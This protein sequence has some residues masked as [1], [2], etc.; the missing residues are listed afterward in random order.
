MFNLYSLTR[1]S[2]GST[3]VVWL[4]KLSQVGGMNVL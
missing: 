4:F 2:L 1:V 3:A